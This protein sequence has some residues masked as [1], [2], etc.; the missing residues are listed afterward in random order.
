MAKNK[1][2]IRGRRGSRT[3]M[4]PAEPLEK[5]LVNWERTMRMVAL[6]ADLDQMMIDMDQPPTFG[7]NLTMGK[8]PWSA[9]RQYLLDYEGGPIDDRFMVA[10]RSP[11]LVDDCQG[12]IPPMVAHWSHT[13]RRVFSLDQDLVEGLID[14]FPDG[15]DLPK[16]RLNL[17]YPAFL[18]TF[19]NGLKTPG[20]HEF[21][22]I[23]VARGWTK[24]S[25][26]ES[27]Y[28]DV[29]F[30]IWP[31][32]SNISKQT[33]SE[34]ELA[35]LTRGL[36]KGNIAQALKSG[37]RMLTW[38]QKFGRSWFAVDYPVDCPAMMTVPIGAAFPSPEDLVDERMDD[39][40]RA[41]MKTSTYLEYIISAFI[42]YLN[43]LGQTTITVG[44]RE[45][46]IRR[47]KNVDL[48]RRMSEVFVVPFQ[49]QIVQGV[50][51]RGATQRDGGPVRPHHRRGHYRRPPGTDPSHPKT[52]W[53][54]KTTVR[55]D[56]IEEGAVIPGTETLIE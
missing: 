52:V 42:L 23:L 40:M 33:V 28:S 9:F 20:G 38:R 5:L 39:N 11:L 25:D 26:R 24:E 41:R 12:Y 16:D 43:E 17:P 53:V 50:R 34:T 32:P 49:S 31:I 30:G 8:V 2:G 55:K 46:P 6:L 22:A 14:M 29:Q 45:E 15:I 37:Q 19:T 48:I 51:I 56:L 3:A 44:N 10:R 7:S 47:H 36:R 54:S 35:E 13:S 27:E 21:S 18:M 1:R 4:H